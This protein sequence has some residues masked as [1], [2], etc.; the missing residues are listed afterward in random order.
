MSW[1]QRYRIRLYVR[2]SLWIL[3]TLSIGVALLT[4]SLLARIESAMG[5]HSSVSPDTARLILSTIAAS[6]FTLLV[7]VSSAMLLAVQLASA[8]LSPRIISMI[9]RMPHGKMAF[10]CFGF[11]FTF[12]VGTLLRIEESFPIF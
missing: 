5:V 11:T 4:V 8:Q 6:T 12:S 10:S 3:P 2:N 9:Y 7:L 1:L